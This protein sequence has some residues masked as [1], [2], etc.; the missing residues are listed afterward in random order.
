V[1][2]LLLLEM[3]SA[4][5]PGRPAFRFGDE[6][7]STGE[8][9]DRAL[10]IG[11]FLAGDGASYLAFDATNS[12]AFPLALFAAAAAGIPLV[13]VNYRLSAD[14]RDEILSG[15]PGALVIA[16][17]PRR[18]GLT[19]AGHRAIGPQEFVSLGSAGEPDVTEPNPEDIAVLL[20][21]SGTTSEPKA[22]VLRH[23][24]LTSYVLG[25]VEFGSAAATDAALVAV[26]PY[27]IAGVAHVL[28]N[29]YAGRRVVY[30]DAFDPEDWLASAREQQVTHAMVVPTMLARIVEYLDESGETAPP[31]LES[32]VY[33]GAA[34][35]LRVLERA[36]RLFPSVGFVNAYGLTETASTI[37][38]LG[39]EDHRRALDDPDP[40]V[41]DRL[42]SAGRVVPG[43]E[44]DIRAPDGGSLGPGEAG[45]IFVRGAQ[46]SG[47]YLGGTS[48][49]DR[50]GWFPTRDTGYVDTEGYLFI[51]GRFDDTIIRGGENI[52]PAEI[53][54]VIALHPDI[55]ECAVVG[56][57]DDEWGQRIVAV[58]V[59]RQGAEL[60]SD[61][62]RA[63]ARSRMRGSRTPD[64]VELRDELPYTE[65]GKLLRR[66]LRT[67]LEESAGQETDT[68]TRE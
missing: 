11:A 31:S 61:G 13:P 42:R 14:R 66:S 59:A 35:P 65:T 24:H 15:H 22:V 68:G 58:V 63:W 44:L 54:E 32:L 53:E 36:L 52:A 16:D 7:L 60:T 41:R 62:V 19:S 40:A 46:V 17:E 49:T 10:R 12:L 56:V 23:R 39:P 33:G 64:Q 26:P 8:L 48:P 21:T 47:E 30:L 29:L 50:S 55:A 5:D 43:V 51:S 34:M 20:Y 38:L 18:S 4:G 1:N 6:E 2:L 9:F 27:H 3:A 67:G 45:E 57:D 25:T 28:T 37:A